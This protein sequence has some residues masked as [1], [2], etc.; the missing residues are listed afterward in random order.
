MHAADRGVWGGGGGICASERER[1]R[2]R[3]LNNLEG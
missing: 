2:E 1:E 3:V